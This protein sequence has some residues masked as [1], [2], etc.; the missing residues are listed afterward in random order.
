[1]GRRV[2]L[3][4]EVDGQ[5]V[6]CGIA[7]GRQPASMVAD[8]G[9]VLAFCDAQPVQP[10]HLLVIPRAHANG[11][12]ELPALDGQAMWSL[13]HR[14]AGALRRSRL[15]CDGVNLFLADGAAAGQEINHVHLHV[16]P[17]VVRDGVFRISANWSLPPRE[18]LDEVAAR[19]RAALPGQA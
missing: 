1:M 4:S 16:V 5:C 13:A 15:R 3:P 6:F 2:S 8:E 19:V 9:D 11:L 10:G 12:A 7:E 17:R 18:R 14:L